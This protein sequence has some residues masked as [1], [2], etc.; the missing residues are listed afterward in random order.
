MQ[1]LIGVVLLMGIAG[2]VLVCAGFVLCM[3]LGAIEAFFGLLGIVF[4]LGGK[5]EK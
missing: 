3:F 5:D 2:V 4:G 1:E